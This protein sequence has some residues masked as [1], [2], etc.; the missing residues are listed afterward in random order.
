MRGDSEILEVRVAVGEVGM[1][2]KCLPEHVGV[3]GSAVV[4]LLEVKVV[5]TSARREE[6]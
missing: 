3:G 5:S 2:C 1:T 6:T 4:L